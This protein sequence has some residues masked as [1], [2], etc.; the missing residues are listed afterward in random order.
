MAKTSDKSEKP[1]MTPEL[2]RRLQELLDEA[3]EL[4]PERRAE[5]VDTADLD[6]AAR[7]RLEGL[8][9]AAEEPATALDHSPLSLTPR[10][11]TVAE[12]RRL[13]AYELLESLDRGGM[14]SVF[15]ARRTDDVHSRKV[16]IKVLQMGLETEEMVRR[17]RREREILA[18]MEHPNIAHLLDGGTAPDGRPFLVMELVEGVP[19]DRYCDEVGAGL[20]ERLRLFQKVCSAVH[21]AHQNLVVH[22]DLKPANILVTSEGVPKLLDFGIA[23]LLSTENFP[24]TVVTTAPDRA[25][26]TP[27]YASPEQIRGERITTASDVYSLGVLLFQLLTGSRPHQVEGRSRAEVQ[28]LICEEEPPL[29]S[30]AVVEDSADPGEARRLRRHLAG[31]LDNI[32]LMALRKEAQRRYIS[33]EQLSED[34]ERHLAGLPVVARK[35]TF[36]YRAGKFVRRHRVAVA[37][38]TTALVLLLGFIQV[39]LVQQREVV[40]QRDR[41]ET[42]AKF[43]TEIFE[44]P[45]PERSE[46]VNLS[47]QQ[48]LERGAA[49]L[50][51][52]LG[53][54]RQL[55]LARDLMQR[56]ERLRERRERLH[57]LLPALRG[58]GGVD[59]TTPQPSRNP[60]Q[61]ESR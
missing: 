23:K 20:E 40:A 53:D 28:R 61:E 54:L 43:L 14:G 52:D 55:E 34:L 33:A 19:I 22:R 5:L 50:D 41:F 56:V 8:I 38:G 24:L 59:S 7:R 25:L 32:V 21:F 27:A 1:A 48:L 39:L 45:N 36:T 6:P 29:P 60:E 4:P 10:R 12:P 11:P 26:M 49:S 57:A 47:A 2:W 30:F 18:Q 51:L 42:T 44:N 17:F 15:I 3:L 16:A 13:G 9:R 35:D 37:S 46:A 31:D 58:A